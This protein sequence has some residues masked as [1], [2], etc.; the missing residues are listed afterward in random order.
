[1]ICVKSST[2]ENAKVRLLHNEVP[3]TLKWKI[4][5][6]RFW[7]GSAV[8]EPATPEQTGVLL[9]RPIFAIYFLFH[10]LWFF[11]EKNMVH[12]LWY[13]LFIFSLLIEF[14]AILNWK[15][16]ISYFLLQNVTNGWKRKFSKF[17][18]RRYPWQNLQKLLKIEGFYG[19]PPYWKCQKSLKIE[20][21]IK[22]RV[23]PYWKCW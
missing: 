11:Y 16:C 3:K 20:S 1:M 22:Y 5:Y 4:V 23:L 18:I 8:W 6:P 12:I 21:F 9:T 13:L 19:V 17:S 14:D 2:F 7:A 10:I 15:H